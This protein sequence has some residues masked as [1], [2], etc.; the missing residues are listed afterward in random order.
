MNKSR[1]ILAALICL[2]LATLS[3][4][5]NK[6]NTAKSRFW[7]A[8]NTR[9]NVY[10]NGETHYIEQLQMLEN[11]YQDD[12]SQHLFIH[13]AEARNVPNV[14]QPNGNFNRTIEKMQKAISLHSIKKKPRRKP[15][16][17]RDPKE[18]EWLSR[19]EY[20]P[21]M[22]NAWI[23][24]GKA[25]YMNGD[26]TAAAATFHYIARH[27]SWL[28][29]VVERARLWESLCYSALG[30]TNEAEN[31]LT[32]VHLNKLS[33]KSDITLYNLA[34]ADFLI[35][36]GQTSEALPFLDRAASGSK[37]AQKTRLQFLLGQLYAE[38]GKRAQ[39]YKAFQ[40]AANANS[41]SYRTKF[42]ARIQQSAVFSGNDIRSE[43][44]AL[45]SMARFDRNKEYLDQI[46]YAIG[47]LYLSHRDTTHAIEN[48]VLAAE[49][50]TRNGIE[51]AISQLKL[52]ELYFIKRQYANAQPCYAEAVSKINTNYP[53]YK[54]I[55]L[56]S[57]VLDELAVYHQNVVLQ[58][59]L[60]K[61]SKLS[62]DDQKRV[63]KKIIDE[64]KAKEKKEKE[65]SEFENRRSQI[66][67]N[68][69]RNAPSATRPNAPA[70][71]TMNTDDSWYFYNNAT[72]QAGK[73][74]F[75][76][77]WGNRKLEDNWRRRNKTVTA[78]ADDNSDELATTNDNA[79]SDDSQQS[80][81]KQENG[82][83]KTVDRANDPHY[84]EYYLKQIPKTEE[85][86][87]NAHNIIQEGLYNIGIILK[88]KLN[89]FGG[90]IASFNEL[91]SRYPDNIYRLDTYYNLYIIY[92][93]QGD[94][95]L[96][97]R[98]RQLI[99]GDFAESTYGIALRDEN[100]IDKLREMP[101]EQERLYEAAYEAYLDNRNDEVH[102]AY[103][104]ITERYPLSDIMPKF[105]F[106]DALA[107]VTEKDYDSFKNGL[108]TL[109][110][111]FPDAEM[112]P[113][114]TSILKQL[115][116]GRVPKREANARGMI[117][118]IK[119]SNDSTA[120]NGEQQA[121]QFSLDP[122]KPH[123]FVFAF[124]TDSV[125]ANELLYNVARHNFNS[126]VIKDFDLEQMTF[127]ALGLLV[128]KSFTN[129]DDAQHYLKVLEEDTDL[130]LPP[131]VRTLIINQD[132]F[133]LMLREG[134]SLEEYLTFALE[135][136]L[137][138]EKSTEELEK[139]EET[140]TEEA[141]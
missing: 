54:Q 118:D 135:S 17:S 3:A 72:V 28:P 26:F 110:E 23:M 123:V 132:D 74:E 60:L 64:L 44:K 128:V 94:R 7:Q 18:K 97:E 29:E 91:L 106:I 116:Q 47:N 89:D 103:Q 5:S 141:P 104:T 121:A 87:A 48:Y 122:A 108:K 85:D 136:K 45:R 111:R 46:Y 81:T 66:E 138:A 11:E 35:K 117:W 25:E 99:L 59:S 1:I 31:A 93:R 80:T 13:P 6:T 119:L 114:A 126:F 84:E 15:G 51:K 100:Y 41:A 38:N 127:G 134:R 39:A 49:K 52:G 75:Q 57:D 129:L 90:A 36:N 30:W 27:F 65:E 107:Y 96:A 62:L 105:M 14:P 16:K 130:Q 86:I 40:A 73:T 101:V 22:H 12:Y 79:T 34:K 109:L 9:Y 19:E 69:M 76:R 70:N 33:S 140:D 133:A 83:E 120:Q 32:L 20:N 61:L 53:N 50:S 21:F 139:L 58:D 63:I 43:V 55:K 125:S 68:A 95:A 67:D 115:N 78:I 56:R 102:Q 131:Q 4:C 124:P 98:Y 113:L 42:N 10:Y 77:R 137:E 2:L 71:F 37:G 112:A 88:D 82:G 8:F 24:L 92:L